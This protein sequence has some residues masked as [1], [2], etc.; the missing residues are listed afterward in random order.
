MDLQVSARPGRGCTVVEVQGDLDMATSPR[1]RGTLQKLVDAGDR[2][3]VVDLAGV[4]F[5]DSS[6]LGALVVMFKSSREA[7]GRLSLAGVR[8]AVR[9]VLNITSVDRVID[10]YDDVPAAEATYRPSAV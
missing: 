7:G 9:R 5:M 3:V 1:L 10:I 2:Q 6:A 8:P 4:A